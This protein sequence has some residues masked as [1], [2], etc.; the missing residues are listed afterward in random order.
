M[1]GVDTTNAC[2][3]TAGPCTA[4]FRT[5]HRGLDESP[6]IRAMTPGACTSARRYTAPAASALVQLMHAD[7]EAGVAA[8]TNG[9]LDESSYIRPLTPGTCTS[10]REYT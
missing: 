2:M 6:Y 10:V 7:A 9:S 5:G 4:G 8:P 3:D 1:H